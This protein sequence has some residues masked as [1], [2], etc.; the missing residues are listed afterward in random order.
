MGAHETNK[1][2]CEALVR[3]F[4]VAGCNTVDTGANPTADKA[5]SSIDHAFDCTRILERLRARGCALP[6]RG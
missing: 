4:L 2:L 1:G 3:A 5:R 6:S